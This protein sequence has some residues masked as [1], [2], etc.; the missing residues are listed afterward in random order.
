MRYNAKP[1]VRWD[2][3]DAFGHVNNAKYLTYVQEARVE[4]LWRARTDVGLEPI[5][6]D[7]VVA[8]AE[9]DYLLPIYEGAMEI[10]CE[11]WVGKIGGAS[12][13]MFY[14]LRSSAG[15]HAKIKTVQVGVDINTKKSRRLNDAE[16]E[17]LMQYQELDG[18][19][20]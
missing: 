1:H 7:M 6:S 9:V 4:M 5:L 2:D 13:D 20:I 11:I 17:Y 14:E 12:F 18:P 10:D 15:L 8:R 3:I 19:A 16:R